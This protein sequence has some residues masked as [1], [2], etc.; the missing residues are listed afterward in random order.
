MKR[1]AAFLAISLTATSPALADWRENTE[2]YIA[3]VREHI[4]AATPT[5]EQIDHRYQDMTKGVRDVVGSTAPTHQQLSAFFGAARESSEYYI[6]YLI[7]ETLPS[8]KQHGITYYTYISDNLPSQDYIASATA[9][10][11]KKEIIYGVGVGLGVATVAATSGWVVVAVAAPLIGKSTLLL[12]A[13]GSGGAMLAKYLDDKVLELAVSNGYSLDRDAVRYSSVIGLMVES[14]Y[15]YSMIP[16]PNAAYQNTPTGKVEYKYD[17]RHRTE[18]SFHDNQG[19]IVN[20]DLRGR[21]YGY[22]LDHVIPV[23]GCWRA[24]VPVA[25][26]ASPLNLQM[27]TSSENRS[28][29]ASYWMALPEFGLALNN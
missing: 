29:G 5:W 12:M 17:V 28:L 23:E 15:L 9:P 18:A 14:S 4:D 8:I 20:S 24:G 25:T 2:A 11:M 21:T 26:C 10:Y 7:S 3:T 1:F 22:D 27:L 16:D 13:A 6:T 19:S